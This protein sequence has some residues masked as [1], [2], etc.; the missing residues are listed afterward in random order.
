MKNIKRLVFVDFDST[1]IN[2][3]EPED[4]KKRYEQVK[5]EKYP[6][7]GWWG[8]KESLD[9]NIHDIKPFEAMVNQVKDE[10]KKPDTHTILLTSRL[11]KLRNEILK[12][13]DKYNIHLDD[14]SFKYGSKDKA[15][16]IK[17]FISKYPDV[18]EIVVYDDREKEFKVLREL[19]KELD[20]KGEIKMHIYKADNGKLSLLESVKKII[21][22]EIKKQL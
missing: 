17:E 15:T 1:L 10:N 14:H 2:S 16:R 6:Y 8:R 3:P 4:G 21:D 5:G 19:K 9:I 20:K 13:L 22:E 7:E 18:E 11:P 12:I